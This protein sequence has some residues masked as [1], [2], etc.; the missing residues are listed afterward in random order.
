M[1]PVEAEVEPF[2]RQSKPVMIT[3]TGE[4]PIDVAYWANELKRRSE[5]KGDLV[6]DAYE[7][8]PCHQARCFKIY[9][10]AVND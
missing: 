3:I 6:Q 5:F 9:P 8:T 2:G 4:D 7:P 10:R 1:E